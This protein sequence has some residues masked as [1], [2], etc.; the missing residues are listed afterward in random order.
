MAKNLASNYRE[1][2]TVVRAN[3]KINTKLKDNPRKCCSICGSELVDNECVDCEI[4]DA[5]NRSKIKK[6]IAY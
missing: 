1:Y 4:K 6:N 2:N 5:K 3:S